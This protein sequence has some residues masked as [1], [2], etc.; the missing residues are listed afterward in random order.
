MKTLVRKEW[1]SLRREYHLY[2]T[3][4]LVKQ[5]NDFLH[6]TYDFV[7]DMQFEL[8]EQD[9]IDAWIFGHYNDQYQG[10]LNSVLVKGWKDGHYHFTQ[11]IELGDFLH[12]L[13]SDEI[14]DQNYTEDSYYTTD[15]QDSV[16]DYNDE[17]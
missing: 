12:D 4:E 1:V 17:V 16:L 10:I 2:V 15:F 5:Y 13:L 7:D 3:P 14:W 8:T 11:P 6:E 9:I